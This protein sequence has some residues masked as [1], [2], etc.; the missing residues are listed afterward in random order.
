MVE[1][2]D[3]D[4]T[5]TSRHKR[6]RPS[7]P[8]DDSDRLSVHA[9]DEEDDIGNLLTEQSS[10]TVNDHTNDDDLLQELEKAFEED[11]TKGSEINAK[12]ANLANQRLASK[13][14]NQDKLKPLLAKYKQPANCTNFIA[15]TVNP[16]ICSQMK[17]HNKSGD[18]T[19]AN[20]QQAD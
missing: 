8:E 4:C 14:L 3:S 13:N 6:Q 2:E 11:D 10:S 18:L 7:E 15:I 19:L 1:S 16:E 9:D 12:L 17:T 5:V 20:M